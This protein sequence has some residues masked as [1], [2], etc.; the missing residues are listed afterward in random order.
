MGLFFFPWDCANMCKCSRSRLLK[1][2]AFEEVLT[3]A[4]DQND[5][6]HLISSTRLKHNLLMLMEAVRVDLVFHRTALCP[7]KTFLIT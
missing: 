6:E 3:L 2:P 1:T 4:N 7:V 5:Q